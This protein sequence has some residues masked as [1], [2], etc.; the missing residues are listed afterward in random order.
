MNNASLFKW[1]YIAIFCKT[2]KQL[3]LKAAS[4]PVGERIISQ[5]TSS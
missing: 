1:Q 3:D 2:Y 4:F 5:V